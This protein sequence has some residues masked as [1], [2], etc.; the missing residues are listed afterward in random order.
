MY[1]FKKVGY[2]TYVRLGLDYMYIMMWLWL[3]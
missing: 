2:V 3:N 1:N